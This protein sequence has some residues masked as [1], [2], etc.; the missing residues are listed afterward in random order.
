V[1]LCFVFISI[2]ISSN[3]FAKTVGT[4]DGSITINP[5]EPNGDHE[6]YITPVDV[7]FHTEDDIQLAYIYY[8]ITTEDQ[9]N[10]NWI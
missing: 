8:R 10:P 3:T 4:L 6:W 7:T 5:A 2:N 9:T 1:N